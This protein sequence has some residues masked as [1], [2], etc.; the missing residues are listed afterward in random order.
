[1][2]DEFEAELKVNYETEDALAKLDSTYRTQLSEIEY[3]SRPYRHPYAHPKK[4]NEK[5]DHRKR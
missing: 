2:G 5:W 1:M 4:P 3:V